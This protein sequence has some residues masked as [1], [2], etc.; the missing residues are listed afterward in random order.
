MVSQNTDYSLQFV[1]KDFQYLTQQKDWTY[2]GVK[3]KTSYLI[4]IIHELL[5]KYYFS[6]AYD[7]KFNLS[8]IILKK[9]YCEY[10]NYY[11]QFLCDNGFMSLVSKYYVGKKTNTY[12][13]NTKYVYDVVRYKNYNSFLLKKAKNRNEI[14]ITE[15]NSSTIPVNIRTKLVEDLNKIDI[16]YDSSINY[17][18]ELKRKKLIDDCKYQKNLMSIENINSKNIYFNFDDYGRFHTNFT[19]LKKEVRNQYLNINNEILAEI[20]ISNSQPLFFAVLLKKELSHINGDTKKYFDLVKNG[21][22]Y[23]DMIKNTNLKTKSEVKEVIYKVLFGDNVKSNKKMNKI[24]RDLYPSVHEYI[25]EF[26]EIKKNYK[27]LSHELQKMESN[28]IFNNVIK[29]IYDTYPE[30]ILFTVHDSILFP[31]SYYDRVKIIYDKH[32]QNLIKIFISN[33]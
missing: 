18:N 8:S 26:K 22:L 11:I 2:K 24:F 13:L 3:L 29:E 4:D 15:M 10:Y 23:D 1:S 27:E 20:D 32:F 6:N 14:T 28:F 12:K 5:Q 16:D 19:I 31:I 30:I 17:L 21:L 33:H 25:L 9:K 7:I